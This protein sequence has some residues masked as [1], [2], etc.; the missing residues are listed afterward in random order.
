ML[1]TRLSK[2]S[3][4]VELFDN[5][6]QSIDL[7]FGERAEVPPFHEWVKNITLDGKPFTYQRHEYLIEPYK[8][9]HPDQTDM[10]AAQMGLTSKAMLKVVYRARYEGYRGILIPLPFQIRRDRL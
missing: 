4:K 3:K 7:E 9:D 6:F 8:D 5:L 1:E 2:D 10:K